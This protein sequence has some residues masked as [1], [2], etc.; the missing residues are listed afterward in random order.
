MIILHF[1][2]QYYSIKNIDVNLS[3]HLTVEIDEF[4]LL[5]D[6]RTPWKLTH[7]EVTFTFRQQKLFFYGY[8]EKSLQAMA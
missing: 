5:S 4:P 2:V 6:K 3:W 1:Q 7:Q 8:N